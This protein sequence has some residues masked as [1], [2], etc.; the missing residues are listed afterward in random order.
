MSTKL[1]ALGLS[2]I[3]TLAMS[4]VAVV[5]ASATDPSP[6]SHFTSEATEHHLIIKGTD[7]FGTTHALK[8]FEGSNTPISCTHS[9]YHG[10]LSGI[11]A[12][13]TQ[14][15]EI[16]PSY[17]SC[18]TTTGT[19]GEVVVHVPAGCGTNVF[20][21]TSRTPPSHGTV[22]I[23]CEIK[24][25]H[26]NCEITIPKQTPKGGIVYD[27]DT[28]NLKHSITGTVTVEEIT[29]HFH[30]GICVFLGT[31]HLF[32][33]EGSATFWGENTAGNPVGVTAT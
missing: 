22:H 9:T 6:T 25:T 1:K 20:K 2:V 7:A 23:E 21:I 24:I 10:T 5:N 8:F 32:K 4:A 26:P 3:A 12:T 14:S 18:A 17:S 29:G 15:I 13:T 28:R 33:M 30:G 27:T 31:N 11:P 16:R 19:W